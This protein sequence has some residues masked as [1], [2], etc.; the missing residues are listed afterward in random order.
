MIY[1]LTA[2]L[3][4]LCVGFSVVGNTPIGE[5]DYVDFDENNVFD[6]DID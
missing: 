3:I 1:L 2:V 4:I 5:P 6:K